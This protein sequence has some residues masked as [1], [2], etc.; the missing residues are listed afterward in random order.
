MATKASTIEYLADQLSSL[1]TI[2]TRKMFGEYALYCDGKTVGLVCDDQLFIKITEQGKAFVDDT[3]EE[4][5]PYP[6]AKPWMRIDEGN[7][8]NRQWLSALVQITA[9]SVPLPKP[10]K[11]K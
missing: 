7:I 6:G 11:K 1:P 4:G 10:K 8:E 2:A 3:Y 9:D 5:E